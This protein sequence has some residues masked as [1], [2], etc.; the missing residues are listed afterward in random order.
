MKRQN[1]WIWCAGT[2]FTLIGFGS[3]FVYDFIDPH[4]ELSREDGNCRIG[5]SPKAK[6]AIIVVDCFINI[7]LTGLFV[8][9]LRPALKSLAV[10]RESTE[11]TTSHRRIIS[12][13]YITDRFQNPRRKRSFRDTVKGMLWRNVI[14]STLI[15]INTVTNNTVFLTV[16]AAWLSHICL[17]TCLTDSKFV[18]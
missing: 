17:L 8:W 9:L 2:C 4:S 6:L 10:N 3:I 18:F 1:D 13:T 14:G 5:I 7:S 15:L 12:A 16:K 11:N